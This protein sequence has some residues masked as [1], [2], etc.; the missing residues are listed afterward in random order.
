MRRPF[1]SARRGA[2]SLVLAMAAI[3]GGLTAAAPAQAAPTPGPAGLAFYTPPEGPPT[4]THGDLVSYRS[5]TVN[6]GPGAPAVNAWNVMYQSSDALGAP[7]Y[8]TGTVLVPTAPASGTRPVVSYAFGSHGL[9]QRCAPSLQ[10]AAGTDYENANLVAALSKGY[11]VVASDYAGYTTG[12]RPTYIVG[13]AEGHAVLDIVKAAS[14]VPNAGV[15]ASAPTAVWGYSQGGQAASWAGEL[16]PTYAPDLQLEAVAAGGIPGDL[17]E[18]ARY[19]DGGTGASFEL[20][21]IIGLAEQYALPIDAILSPAGQE[22]FAALKSQCVFEALPAL[23]NKKLS[24]FTVGGLSLDQ[25]LALEFVADAVDAQRV[26]TKKVDVPVYAYHGQADQFIPL[27]QAYGVKRRYCAL[28]TKVTW[29]LYP[30]E[31]ITT[32]FQAA[33]RSLSFIADRFAGVAATDN[34][35][36]NTPPASTA[37]PNGGDFAVELDRWSLDGTVHLATLNQDITLPEGA[38]FSADA[39]LTTEA[40]TG[41]LS[42]P[43]FD[44]PINLFGFLPLTSKIALEPA[45]TTGT[46]GLDTNGQLEIGGLAKATIVVK[47]LSLFGIPV[48]AAECRTSTP[49][50]FP[51]AFDGGLGALGSGKLTFTGAATIPTVVG[52]EQDFIGSFVGLFLTAPNNTFSFTVTPPAPVAT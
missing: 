40:L 4:G 15:S 49:V 1:R 22:A 29:D 12:G 10:L 24:D 11:A 46:V 44:S 21:A 35:A 30:S 14:Q 26:G 50:E 9:A 6:L 28:G 18:T 8:V 16:Q 51:L 33:S 27:A 41:D 32:Q 48:T 13:A 25:L 20:A 47:Q 39:N 7:V 2:A 42:V 17:A 37:L 38:T 5:A 31:H 19:L 45:G 36:Q 3:A 52:C 23:R 43:T 34:C